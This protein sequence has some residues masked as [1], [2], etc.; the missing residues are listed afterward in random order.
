VQYEDCST[1][2]LLRKIC[3]DWIKVNFNRLY[4][5]SLLVVSSVLTPGLLAQNPA[6]TN[7][8]ELVSP[9]PVAVSSTTSSSEGTVDL[10]P[11]TTATV[12]VAGKA[13]PAHEV[14]TKAFSAVGVDVKIGAG[15]IGFG[16]ATPLGR[17]FNLRGTG[18]FFRYNT[19][20]T[21]DYVTYGGEIQL[22][23]GGGS[24]DWFPFGGSFRLSAGFMAYNGNQITGRASLN[25]DESFTLNGNTYYS[26]STDPIHASGT[27]HMGSVA[28]PTFGFGWGNIVPRKANKHFSVP[29]EIGVAYV[30]YPHVDLSFVGS[31]CDEFGTA[32]QDVSNNP[33][34]QQDL[35]AQRSKYQADL[36]ALRFYPILSIGFGY[37]F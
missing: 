5:S 35:S 2:G 24:L 15:G 32:C 31:T 26:S 30:G 12:A 1:V 33:T 34:F 27:L 11:A 14:A 37:K 22:A 18:Y 6:N 25:P 19:S 17:K 10:S 28:A 13:E 8:A 16:V 7:V 23:S 20:I 3:S 9:A 36:S 29:V 4:L 21:E